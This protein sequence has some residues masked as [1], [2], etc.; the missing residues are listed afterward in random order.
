MTDF[1]ESKL[2]KILA[3]RI[4]VPEK[5]ANLLPFATP[6]YCPDNNGVKASKVSI[7]DLN[8]NS[9]YTDNSIANTV[10]IGCQY[11]KVAAQ[12]PTGVAI[13]G[14]V[15]VKPDGTVDCDTNNYYQVDLDA[16][17]FTTGDNKEV[18]ILL[19]NVPANADIFYITRYKT[20]V[21]NDASI[22]NLTINFYHADTNGTG[23]KILDTDTGDQINLS[24]GMTSAKVQ[25]KFPVTI[26]AANSTVF[27]LPLIGTPEH[28]EAVTNPSNVK[29]TVDIDLN[30][31]LNLN[32]FVPHEVDLET[33][34]DLMDIIK[35]DFAVE[36]KHAVST[37]IHTQLEAL[38]AGNLLPKITMAATL[39]DALGSAISKVITSG[40][41]Q[42]FSIY[43]YSNGA[44]IEYIKRNNQPNID[45]V[46]QDKYD[47][48]LTTIDD[49]NVPALYYFEKPTL[50]LDSNK[51]EDY[52]QGLCGGTIKEYV[53]DVIDVDTT[54]NSMT[55][56]GEGIFGT[57][58]CFAVAFTQPSI[59]RKPSQDMFGDELY[60][61]IYY[62][63][64]LINKTNLTV[65]E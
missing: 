44:P 35:S 27:G 62:G 33:D 4:I 25:F 26:D 64:K 51:F 32:Y 57:N 28:L 13:V 10:M 24:G 7:I 8:A 63:V 39:S 15:T 41:G 42:K 53:R 47:F 20:T 61:T 45:K 49:I 23:Y 16:A 58:D 29:N 54:A 1:N 50:I 46:I 12:G 59:K 38:V 65:F 3:R 43:K 19:K 30:K 52:Q 5:R 21:K 55:N 56:I 40:T 34:V 2:S 11:K 17:G 37:E 48:D 31:T 18:I 14:N 36:F 22:R 60:I 9:F 6:I